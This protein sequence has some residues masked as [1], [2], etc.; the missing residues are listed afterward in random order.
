MFDN[1]LGYLK[2]EGLNLLGTALTNPA[3]A[4]IKVVADALGTSQSPQDIEKEIRQNPEAIMK[5]KELEIK[6]KSLLQEHA[7]KVLETHNENTSS[8]RELYKVDAESQKTLVKH[9]NIQFYFSVAIGLI[10]LFLTA[11][12]IQDKG[13]AMAMTGFISSIITI[14]TT[15]VQVLDNFF[16]GSSSS[17]KQ[18]TSL[19]K[20]KK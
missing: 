4:V 7:L 16:F 14:V 15:R 2:D 20:E 13:M 5:L 9:I 19:L 17:S 8:A 10:T 6:E 1:I 11:K 3:G 12:Y 18:K